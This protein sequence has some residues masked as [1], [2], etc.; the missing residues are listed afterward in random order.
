M[1]CGPLQRIIFG[2]IGLRN[3]S[4]YHWLVVAS[5]ACMAMTSIGICINCAGIFFVSVS[6]ALE[7]G[8]GAISMTTTLNNLISGVMGPIVASKLIGKVN[9]RML[10]GAGAVVS[11]LCFVGMSISNH[12]ALFY[13]LS[14]LMG[15]FVTGYNNVV[16]TYIIGNWFQEKHGF[17]MGITMSCSGLGGAVFNPILSAAIESFGWR[18]A[19]LLAGVFVFVIAMPGIV[20]V[21]RERPEEK[22]LLAYGAD[23]ISVKSTAQKAEQKVKIS[24]FNATF[25]VTVAFSVLAYFVSGFNTHVSGFA[26]SIG[27]SASVGALMVSAGMIGNVLFKLLLGVLSDAMGAPK[28]CSVM[29]I[30]NM[31][32]MTIFAFLPVGGTVVPMLSALFFG[33]IFA[34][35]AV[36]I[37]LVVRYVYGPR[38]NSVAYSYI[39]MFACAS[40]SAAMALYGFSF[41]FFGSYRVAIIAS[42]VIA[43][44]SLTCLC[45]VHKVRTQDALDA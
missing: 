37:P 32:G 42:V 5:C 33:G 2:G 8:R 39:S 21:I 41:D 31:I 11:A 18:N 15:I 6:E 4:I 17:A 23:S 27:L 45:F 9:I 16:I 10:T 3:K 35:A 29:L 7:V 30:S 13:V 28:A 24:F 43:A 40:S 22:N 44:L 36:G 14:V 19:Y 25:L 12:V 34:V 1:R 26:T 20:F 38:M